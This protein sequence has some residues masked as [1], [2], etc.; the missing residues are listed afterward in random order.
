MMFLILVFLETTLDKGEG[1]EG[2]H[3]F[4]WRQFLSLQGWQEKKIGIVSQQHILSGAVAIIF[5]DSWQQ[6][7][8]LSLSKNTAKC[9]W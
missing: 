6:G 1:S 5:H 8:I 2:K 4:I 7:E 3:L 9:K